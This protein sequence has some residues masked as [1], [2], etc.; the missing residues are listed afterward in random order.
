MVGT[1][2]NFFLLGTYRHLAASS[3]HH[4]G[5]IIHTVHGGG[6]TIA[7]GHTFVERWRKMETVANAKELFLAQ[8]RCFIS[9][10]QIVGPLVKLVLREPTIAS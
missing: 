7:L 2:K 5:S 8:K 1:S 10:A 4:M 3:D 9:V 6:V